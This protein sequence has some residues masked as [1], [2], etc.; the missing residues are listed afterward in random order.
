[1]FDNEHSLHL[2]KIHPC[3]S[4]VERQLTDWP[5][6]VTA[7]RD[8]RGPLYNQRYYCTWREWCVWCFVFKELY[9][10]WRFH[11]DFL[12]V[13]HKLVYIYLKHTNCFTDPVQSMGY[14]RN[15]YKFRV[16]H[17][18]SSCFLHVRCCICNWQQHVKYY[19]I[20]K[21]CSMFVHSTCVNSFPYIQIVRTIY[22]SIL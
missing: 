10:R 12:P 2:L 18:M 5:E 20:L 6:Q 3:T 17:C 9:S 16:A 1:V 4:T 21:F 7:W 13:N 14:T 22:L 19:T 11:K 15:M 8:L